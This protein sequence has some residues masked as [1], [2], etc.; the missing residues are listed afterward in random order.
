MILN[1]VPICKIYVLFCVC[2]CA[3]HTD[4]EIAV[5]TVAV[6]MIFAIRVLSKILVRVTE[7][8]RTVVIPYRRNMFLPFLLWK[9]PTCR[10]VQQVVR[11]YVFGGVCKLFGNI[12][13]CILNLRNYSSY[14]EKRNYL[15]E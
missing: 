14:V 11:C 6:Y 12:L 15:C 1:A 7:M 8:N 3:K 13:S 9:N 4:L 2:V 5:I 10:A